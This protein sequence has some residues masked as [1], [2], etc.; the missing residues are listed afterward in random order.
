MAFEPHDRLVL[1]TGAT[2][3]VGGRLVLALLN[4][5]FKVRVFV[6]NREK[7]LSQPWAHLVDIAEGDANDFE[8]T[9]VAL[10]GVHTAFYLLHSINAGGR[11]D[12]IEAAMATN[13][14][15]AAE[16]GNVSQIVYLGG[17]ANAAR[18]SKHLGS[19]AN[20][21]KQLASGKVPVLELR[22]GIIIGSGSASFEMV[23][24][25]THRLP[26]MLTPKWVR[27]LTQPIA[28]RDVLYYLK[29]TAM[30]EQPISDI[31][32]IGG[33][34]I[35]AYEDLIQAF[36]RVSQLRQRI[37]FKSPFFTVG[38]SSL[39]IGFVT[40]VPRSLAKPLVG[41]LIN[42][43]VA[44][45]KKSIDAW[46]APPQEGLLPM[47]AAFRL[48]L[49]KVD[50]HL[51]ESRWSD[52]GL[53]MPPWQKVQGDPEWSGAAEY[54]DQRVVLAEASIES[55]W[56]SIEQIGGE[57]G[58]YGSD[59]LWWLRGLI[60]QM[61]GG[62]GLR[63]GRRD[64]DFLR[65]GES[66]DFWRVEL[67][68]CNRALT[69][70]AEMI[71]PGKAWLSFKLEEEISDGKTFTKMTQTATFQPKGLGGRLYW[72]VVYPFHGFIFPT[73]VTNIVRSAKRRDYAKANPIGT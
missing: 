28:I 32:D 61:I 41:S 5:D 27:N 10:E 6:R 47:E 33:P 29:S 62:V 37:V 72:A 20:T 67:L 54:K 50:A 51:V 31:F 8:A 24:H 48:A 1:V 38:V 19:R 23:R 63:R 14:S 66:L 56:K 70:F 25:L 9:R 15:K 21:G 43:A 73:M 34:D 71:L 7:M 16:A 68:E 64:P 65:Q 22:A 3:Y 30:L 59:W 13:F 58:W 36:A 42:E 60:D 12:D 69:L 52:A 44:D 11:F 17:I 57:H 49:D 40:P 4:Q 18:P 45:P 2:G 55:M 26:L 35:L 39:F 46:I 53:Y